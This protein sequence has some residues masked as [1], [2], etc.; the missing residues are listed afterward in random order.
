[1]D[2]SVEGDGGSVWRRLPAAAAGFTATANYFVMDWAAVAR[3][4][5]GGLL[6]AGA[7]AAWVPDSFWQGFFLEGHLTRWRSCGGRSSRR[8][9]R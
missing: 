6:I 3:D 9:W 2:M 7:L 4:V 8:R 5:F 1:M